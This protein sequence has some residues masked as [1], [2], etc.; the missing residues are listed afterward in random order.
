MFKRIVLIVLLVTVAMGTAF[1][2]KKQMLGEAAAKKLLEKVSNSDVDSNEVN[3]AINIITKYAKDAKS[4]TGVEFGFPS[5]MSSAVKST[6]VKQIF[7]LIDAG[8]GILDKV[9][10]ISE[11][12]GL[13][14]QYWLYK[15]PDSRTKNLKKTAKLQFDTLD[16]AAGFFVGGAYYKAGIKAARAALQL[17]TERAGHLRWMEIIEDPFVFQGAKRTYPKMRQTQ[18]LD[19]DYAAFAEAWF[20]AAYDPTNT[21]SNDLGICI[22]IGEYIW[23]LK[24]LQRAGLL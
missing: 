3:D 11:A 6:K 9:S 15:D 20:C 13:A 16:F 8:T 24:T 10:T 22:K 23:A 19:P 5:G 14:K 7:N 12:W 1:A 2:Q 4:G 21:E 18:F 17:I